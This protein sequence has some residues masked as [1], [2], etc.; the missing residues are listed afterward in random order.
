MKKSSPAPKHRPE[1]KQC[2]KLLRAG[3]TLVVWKLDHLGRS[4]QQLINVVADLEQRQVGFQSLTDNIDTTSSTVKLDFHIFGSLVEFERGLTRE[5]VNAGLDAAKK[6]GKKFGRPDAL[7]ENYKDMALAMRNG[8]ATKFDIAGHFNVIRHT[9]YT[10]LKEFG[11]YP[12][13]TRS[14]S[15]PRHPEQNSA[16]D[17]E[18]GLS[19]RRPKVGKNH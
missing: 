1:L 10:L 2:L 8:E 13:K 12:S 9:I 15:S 17:L 11:T 18:S 3:D 5:R 6:K 16:N 19:R 4:L 7:S 14:T